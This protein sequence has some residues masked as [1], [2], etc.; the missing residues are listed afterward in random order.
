MSILLP[1]LSVPKI[2]DITVEQLHT[3]NIKALILDADDTLSGH[4]EQQLFPG[5]SEWLLAMKSAGFPML[6]ASNNFRKRVEPFAKQIGLPFISLS[7]KPLPFKL[8]WATRRLGAKRKE[9]AIIG[10][11]IFTD[12]LGAN[13]AGLQSIL[14][15]PESMDARFGIRRKLEVS[16]REKIAA[17]SANQKGK[18]EKNGNK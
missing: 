5:V 11:Q 14:V 13:F 16:I 8:L 6:I 3:L 7:V 12:I 2:T 15:T 17:D 9:T 4:G 10:D 1:T 18:E